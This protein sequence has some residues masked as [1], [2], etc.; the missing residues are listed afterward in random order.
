MIGNEIRKILSN[1]VSLTLLLVIFILNGVLIYRAEAPGESYCFGEEELRTV[2]SALPED[3]ALALATLREN[4]ARLQAALDGAEYPLPLLT[5]DLYS[6]RD[7]FREVMA[8]VEPVAGYGDYLEGVQENV[9]V[10]TQ[11]ELVGDVNSFGYQNLLRSGQV[12]SNLSHVSPR[13]FY[14]GTAE[15]LGQD[16][17]TDVLAVIVCVLFCLELMT[18]EKTGGTLCLIKPTKKGRIPLHFTKLAAAAMLTL[19]ALLIL[20]G[21]GLVIN[22]LRYGIGDLTAPIQSVYGFQ[23]SPWDISL[24]AYYLLFFLAKYLWLLAIAA[25]IYLACTLCRNAVSSCALSV[26]MLLPGFFLQFFSSPM[27]KALSLF[28]FGDTAAIFFDLRNLN[29]GEKPMNSALV[30]LL[31]TIGTTLLCVIL[32]ALVYLKKFPVY[33]IA[34]KKSR[35]SGLQRH[36]GLFYHEAYKLFWMNRGLLILLMFLGLQI[37]SFQSFSVNFSSYEQYYRQYS[38]VLNGELT[39]EKELYLQSEAERY[40]EIDRKIQE[41]WELVA[42]GEQSEEAAEVICSQL[43]LQKGGEKAFAAVQEQYHSMAEI[44][45]DYVDLTG[46]ER[47]LGKEGR[48]DLLVETAKLFSVLILGLSTVFA[49]EKETKMELLLSISIQKKKSIR[50]KLLLCAVLCMIAAVIAYLPQVLAVAE[51]CGLGPLSSPAI[52]VPILDIDFSSIGGA[53]ALY[54]TGAF[55]LSLLAGGCILWFSKRLGNTVH[56]IVGSSVILLLPV[57]SLLILYR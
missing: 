2:Y 52:S 14:S 25:V 30:S 22:S 48:Y 3:P 16:R 19:C 13:A 37:W 57:A 11:S 26:L 29:V 15:R 20:Y 12:Y 40:A 23:T 21:T 33:E 43:N 9:T 38:T 55:F 31:V 6:E 51:H 32:S 50:Y 18:V 49:Q 7:L 42:A 8:R 5:E 44:G 54:G 10:L 41:Q 36:H 53:F 47:L 45:A 35:T 39:E 1:P 46:F 27:L 28:S 34:A 17:T 4:E 24:L 56:T